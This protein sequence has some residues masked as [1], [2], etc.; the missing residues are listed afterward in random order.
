VY[1]GDSGGGD[2]DVKVGGRRVDADLV[3]VISLAVALLA[4]LVA[5]ALL[6][7]RQGPAQ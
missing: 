3:G 1:D 2:A 6:R 5:V 4:L 7:R